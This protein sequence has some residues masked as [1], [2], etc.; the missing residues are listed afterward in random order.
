MPIASIKSKVI[1]IAQ[2]SSTNDNSIVKKFEI[3]SSSLKSTPTILA[4]DL[5]IE[6]QINSVGLIEIEG[7]I[8]GTINGNS[9][10]LREGGKIEGTIIA[11]SLSLRGS[12]NGK[13]KAKNINIANKAKVHGEIE[14]GSLS[15]EDGACIDGQFKR[16]NYKG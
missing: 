5:E 4:R 14:Y 11:E 13:I 8:K 7:S 6:G 2:N 1:S 12:F 16:V 9:V 3:I 15:V 10:I